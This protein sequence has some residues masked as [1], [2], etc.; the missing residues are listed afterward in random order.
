M[1]YMGTTTPA[2]AEKVYSKGSQ[3]N[4]LQGI[5]TNITKK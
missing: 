5:C 2:E 3:V 1:L 4:G